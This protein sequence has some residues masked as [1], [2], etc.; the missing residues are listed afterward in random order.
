M[1][2]NRKKRN[3][4]LLTKRGPISKIYIFFSISLGLR[5]CRGFDVFEHAQLRN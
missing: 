4:K 2:G 5:Q 3:G 1:A